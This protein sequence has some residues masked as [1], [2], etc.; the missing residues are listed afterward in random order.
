MLRMSFAA[1]YATL[2]TVVMCCCVPDVYLCHLHACAGIMG[3]VGKAYPEAV[4]ISAAKAIDVAKESVGAGASERKIMN[5]ACK[6]LRE[7]HP[8]EEMSNAGRIIKR[9]AEQFET[10]GTVRENKGRGRKRE[11]STAG[12]SEVADIVSAGFQWPDG[13]PSWFR[14]YKHSMQRSDRV[15]EITQAAG[16]INERTLRRTMHERHPE[17]RKKRLKAEPQLTDQQMEARVDCATDRETE[18]AA[19]AD[20]LKRTVFMDSKMYTVEQK[21]QDTTW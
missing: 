18:H 20:I 21:T 8:H 7:Q 15:R 17:I 19:D 14:S 9:C 11:L 16:N 10:T 3:R 13:R 4:S 1:T 12:S 2:C 6:W 5:R